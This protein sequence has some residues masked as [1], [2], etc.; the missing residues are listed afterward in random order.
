MAQQ[1]TA[2]RKRQRTST[3]KPATRRP[4][5]QRSPKQREAEK[6]NLARVKELGELYR[7]LHEAAEAELA[8][9]ASGKKLL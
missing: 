2:T 1:V 6:Q 3:R 8:K 9:S 4:R 7:P 5:Q